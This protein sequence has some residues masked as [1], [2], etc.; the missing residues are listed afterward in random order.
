MCDLPCF[1]EE[2]CSV[3]GLILPHQILVADP[4]GSIVAESMVELHHPLWCPLFASIRPSSRPLSFAPGILEKTEA[5]AI[6]LDSSHDRIGMA[7][8]DAFAFT[9]SFENTCG[10]AEQ[11]FLIH[12]EELVPPEVFLVENVGGE[13]LACYPA[14]EVFHALARKTPLDCCKVSMSLCVCFLQKW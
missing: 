5:M 11:E 14:S 13:E 10:T 6:N 4:E 7:F 3:K 12:F 1:V 2:S 8:F 9:P